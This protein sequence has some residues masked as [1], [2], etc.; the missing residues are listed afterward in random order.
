MQNSKEILFVNV[1]HPK[2][3]KLEEFAKL[4]VKDFT[5]Y[6]SKLD[7]SISNEFYVSVNEQGD[8]HCVNIARFEDLESYYRGTSTIT[9][10]NHI[11]RIKPLLEG[12]QP[13][14][15]KKVW[16]SGDSE[17]EYSSQEPEAQ[18]LRDLDRGLRQKYKAPSIESH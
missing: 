4:Q 7:G 9:F 17:K 16:Q 11:E 12:T 2:K 3:G 15:L 8:G 14:L 5:T 13:M 1:I 10:K 18:L 6:G